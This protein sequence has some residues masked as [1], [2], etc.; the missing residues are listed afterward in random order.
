MTSLL[1]SS[2][3]T[4]KFFFSSSPPRAKKLT[5]LLSVL[6]TNRAVNAD[7]TGG[8]AEAVLV[9]ARCGGASVGPDGEAA[10][11]GAGA[12]EEVGAGELEVAGAVALVREGP[13]LGLGV[14]GR[15]LG[16][17]GVLDDALAWSS[18]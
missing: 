12:G 4:N 17:G 10:P 18:S 1:I 9:A 6:A 15:L 8:N 3:Q 11:G 14:G 5:R 13:A 16:A 7:D 2:K